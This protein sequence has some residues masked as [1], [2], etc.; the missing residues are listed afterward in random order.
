M[1]NWGMWLGNL[2]VSVN[3]VGIF[4]HILNLMHK[5]ILRISAIVILSFLESA[6]TLTLAVDQIVLIKYW[7]FLGIFIAIIFFVGLYYLNKHETPK[8]FRIGATIIL[9]PS[10]IVMFSF[11]RFDI[12]L[13]QFVL[14]KKYK[15]IENIEGIKVHP[16]IHEI[17]IKEDD[18]KSKNQSIDFRIGVCRIA[19]DRKDRYVEYLKGK[20]REGVKAKYETIK[21][22]RVL[23]DSISLKHYSKIYNCDIL[24]SG[25]RNNS[26]FTT[27]IFTEP[28]ASHFLNFNNEDSILANDTKILIN[29]TVEAVCFEFPKIM[30]NELNGITSYIEA[31]VEQNI[32]NNPKKAILSYEKAFNNIQNCNSL[33][34][35]NELSARILENT[36]K[37]YIRIQNFPLAVKY[38]KTIIENSNFKTAV[39]LTAIKKL[40][41]IYKLSIQPA[42]NAIQNANSTVT[43]EEIIYIKSR[44][45]DYNEIA[46]AIIVLRDLIN[47]LT[48]KQI[49]DYALLEIIEM[50]KLIQDFNEIYS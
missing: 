30:I 4:K 8:R 40:M 6:T 46:D 38:Y 17:E 26:V 34:L 43:S 37:A 48:N 36:A 15:N 9:I 12:L 49:D 13:K 18:L 3:L 28:K 11:Y 35:K 1:Q 47:E 33:L 29:D 21:I 41:I 14:D 10:L 16:L 39:K 7:V 32:N 22:D 42:F 24:I 23:I 5:K 27:I 25:Y 2:L 31:S 20:L 19:N 50:A 44:I 45:N